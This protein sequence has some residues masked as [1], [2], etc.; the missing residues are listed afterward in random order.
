MHHVGRHLRGTIVHDM[1][2]LDGRVALVHIVVLQFRLVEQQ[3]A[4]GIRIV[5]RVV[6]HLGQYH[7]CHREIDGCLRAIALDSSHLMEMA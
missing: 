1:D 3:I 2:L 6:E 7:T 5:A 4:H